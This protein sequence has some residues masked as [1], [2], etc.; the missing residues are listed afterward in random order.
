MERW[1]RGAPGTG[2]R[3]KSVSGC[4]SLPISFLCF[5]GTDE[6][7]KEMWR[8]ESGDREGEECESNTG[9]GNQRRSEMSGAAWGPGC[10]ACQQRELVRKSVLGEQKGLFSLRMNCNIWTTQ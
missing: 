6:R 5:L 2:Q 7:R 4:L 1:P 3:G 10:Q 9:A 8:C